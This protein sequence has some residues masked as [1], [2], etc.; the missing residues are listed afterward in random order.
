M[1]I[2]L[3]INGRNRRL[4]VPPGTTLLEALRDYAG[5]TGT[6]YGCGEGQCGACTVLI[7]GRAGK[8]C[9][10][11]A[12][13]AAGSK[14]VTIEGLAAGPDLHPVQQAFLD[15]AAFQ[16]GF[17]T[18]GMILG[19]VSLL[20][21]EPNPTAAGIRE[22]LEGHICRCGTYPRIVDAVRAAGLKMRESRRG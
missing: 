9:T 7:D 2:E 16:C 18:P 6:K 21:E 14:I 8:S 12:A 5:L 3:N 15:L 17:C 1:E 10:V 11:D 22:G 20:A 4:E 13:S 19:A